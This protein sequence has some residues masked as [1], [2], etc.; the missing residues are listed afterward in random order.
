MRNRIVLK[1]L[2]I[3]GVILFTG[4]LVSHVFLFIAENQN[5][6]SKT[7]YLKASYLLFPL[8]YFSAYKYAFM[9]LDQ[10][11]KDNDNEM[12]LRSIQ[13]F[14]KSIKLNP[15]YYMSHH[16][17]GKAY[18]FYNYPNSEFFDHGVVE[19]KRA[20]EIYQNNL[21]MVRDTSEVMLSMWPLISEADKQLLQ[22]M[23]LKYVYRFSWEEFKP[24][25]ELW[26]LY[27]KKIPFMETLLK[28]NPS[29]LSPVARFL[30]KF[31]GP[32]S[33]R[34]SFLADYESYV[35]KE[36]IRKFRH[37]PLGNESQIDF[38]LSL[39]KELREIKR[40]DTLIPGKK[41]NQER[42]QKYRILLTEKRI[43][44]LINKFNRS[45]ASA[46]KKEIG[47]L[48]L[49]YMNTNPE[50][51]D[52]LDLENFLNRKGF[53]KDNDFGSLYL[54]FR[55][56]FNQAD[57]SNVIDEIED[58]KHSI[59]YI[60]EDQSSD[61]VEILLLLSDAY[62]SSKLLTVADTT[63]KDILKISP[64]NL[65]VWLRLLRIQRVLGDR[66]LEKE[67]MFQEKV[68]RLKQSRFLNLD[69]QQKE[70]S[71]FLI[72]KKE[73]EVSVDPDL[74]RNLKKKKIIQVFIQGRIKYEEYIDHLPQ[75]IQI[76][77]KGLKDLEKVMVEVL[78]L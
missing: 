16:H 63:L 33:L 6:A 13:W 1:I 19:L 52:L 35:L 47:Q 24:L 75:V 7:K 74:K 77:L 21:I 70:F 39:L 2:V 64:D 60:K 31:E 61:Y 54:K 66:D 22:E 9:W 44:L 17:L 67:G 4:R 45:M 78:F 57:F 38:E 72:D 56:K 20:V 15:F 25:V 69:D 58:L 14:K 48:I 27:S 10:G 55:L 68:A 26:W 51:K 49:E 76:D 73:I 8:D 71:V 42:Y 53:F 50:F 34:W 40:Y 12:L 29:F 11:Y 3:I 43:K 28:K 62:E 59:S 23:L 36:V 5:R 65:D 18:L 32:L 46:I 30:I 41:F 37:G